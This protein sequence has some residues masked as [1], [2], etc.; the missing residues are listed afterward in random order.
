MQDEYAGQAGTFINDPETG[1]RIP[2][3]EFEAAQAA[4]NQPGAAA[5]RALAKKAPTE[6]SI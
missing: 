4:K 2:I 3:E 5:P 1:T 6:E